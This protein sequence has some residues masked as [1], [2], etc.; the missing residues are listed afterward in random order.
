M[1]IL[2]VSRFY[3]AENF[4]QCR[5]KIQ[6]QQEDDYTSKLSKEVSSFCISVPSSQSI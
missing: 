6:A 4:S 1:L 5:R 3:D 2:M